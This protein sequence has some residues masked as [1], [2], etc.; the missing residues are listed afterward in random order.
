[1]IGVLGGMGPAATVD[2]LAKLIQATP[3][4][5]DQDHLPVAVI[6]DPRV[7][8][9]VAPILTGEG[10]SPLPAL[11]A[12]AQALER[13]GA[14]CIAMPCHTA[15]YWAAE[16]AAATPLPLLH[17][18]DAVL[19]ELPARVAPPG[20]VG[21][22]ATAATLKA[23]LYQPRLV[24]AGYRC[25]TPD[26][27]LLNGAVLP[28][29]ALVK[30]GRALAA[31]PLLAEALAALRREGSRCTLL[32]CTELPLALAVLEPPPADCLDATLALA[33]TCLAWAERR[34]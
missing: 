18:A 7:P 8:D 16:L 1:M 31:A 26:A 13:A 17:I 32:A 30:Q 10:P 2:F 11:I 9:R 29:I 33:R 3:A 23:Q 27:V 5:R 28:A 20:P 21:L 4:T 15:H 24:A 19:A 14:G 25:L 34:R 6:S 22:L 12:G